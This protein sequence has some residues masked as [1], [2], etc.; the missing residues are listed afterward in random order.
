MK[1]KGFLIMYIYLYKKKSSCY[2]C[3]EYNSGNSTRVKNAVINC[4]IIRVAFEEIITQSAFLF[5][6][7]EKQLHYY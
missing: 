6:F 5:Q 1:K 2:L 3:K 7:A 4:A